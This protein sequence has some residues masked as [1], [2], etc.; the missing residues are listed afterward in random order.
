MSRPGRAAQVGMLLAASTVVVGS[1]GTGGAA[2]ASSRG[3]DV[4]VVAHAGASADAPQNTLAAVRL[5]I[6]QGADVIEND[7]QQTADGELVV[8]HDTSLART[9]DVEQV[10]PDRAPWHVGDFTLA[11]IKRLDAG[12]WYG[13]QYVGERVPTLRQWAVAA[14]D[15]GMMIEAKTP[16]LYP[17]IEAELARQLRTYAVFERARRADRLVVMSFNHAWLRAFDKRAPRVPVGLVFGTR[18]THREIWMASSWADAIVPVVGLVD[19]LAIDWAHA[20]GMEVFVWT[21]D[22][23]RDMRRVIR[24]GADGVITSYPLVLDTVLRRWTARR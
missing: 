11:E 16:E 2:A 22:V 1:L 15:R 20:H 9:T 7:F 17:G 21:I 23:V 12:S 4:D 24:W 13:P 3:P 5:A 19:E 18:P 8:V 14:G 10:F 6:E